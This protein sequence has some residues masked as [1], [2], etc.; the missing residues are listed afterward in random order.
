VSLPP[1]VYQLGSPGDFDSPLAR[2]RRWLQAEG[3]IE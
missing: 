3:V 1:A 2:F